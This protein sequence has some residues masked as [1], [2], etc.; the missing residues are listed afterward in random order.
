MVSMIHVLLMCSLELSVIITCLGMEHNIQFMHCD[1]EPLPLTM[2]RAN[3]WPG[4]PQHPRYAFTFNLLDWAE[5]LLLESH[6][7]LKDFCN[8]LYFRCPYP[9]TKVFCVSIN[10]TI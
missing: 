3:L 10:K 2:V 5:A 7:A 1:C 8:S 4:T 9:V 6:V